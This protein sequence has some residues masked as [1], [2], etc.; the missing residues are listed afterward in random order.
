MQ[1]KVYIASGRGKGLFR[2][3]EE[4]SERDSAVKEDPRL[5][6]R[7]PPHDTVDPRVGWTP[8]SGL[9]PPRPNASRRRDRSGIERTGPGP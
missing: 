8:E 7:G 9:G 6:F 5:L 4:S 2:R 3:A 1:A